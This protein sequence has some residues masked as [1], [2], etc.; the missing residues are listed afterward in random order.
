MKIHF[1]RLLALAVLAWAATLQAAEATRNVVFCAASE[2][3]TYPQVGAEEFGMVADRICLSPDEKHGRA[4]V[5]GFRAALATTRLLVIGPQQDGAFPAVDLIFADAANCEAVRSFLKAGGTL[6][7]DQTRTD[8][9][10]LAKFL[11]EVG[12][13]PPKAGGLPPLA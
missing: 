2:Y 13:T 11:A 3:A 1:A 9:A 6:V 4:N 7:F 5:E 12:V 8:T 10:G